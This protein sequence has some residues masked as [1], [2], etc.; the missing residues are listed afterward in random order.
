MI[1]YENKVSFYDHCILTIHP[2]DLFPDGAIVEAI[3]WQGNCFNIDKIIVFRTDYFDGTHEPK[4][5]RLLELNEKQK[6]F[7]T[8][9]LV[10][11][12]SRHCE[13]IKIMELEQDPKKY[14]L[15]QYER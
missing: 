10:K 4:Y 15:H 6:E 1:D 8:N 7:I 14:W 9:M 11:H 12:Y 3:P 13:F 2:Q 5:L